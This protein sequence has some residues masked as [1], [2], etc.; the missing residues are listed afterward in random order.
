KAVEVIDESLARVAA[1]LD[2][3][4]GEM[5][6]TAD[7]GN[8]EQLHDAATGQ[9]HTAHT[10]NLVPFVYYGAR[11]VRMDGVGVPSDIAPSLLVLLGLPQP[12]EMT[13]KALLRI[14]GG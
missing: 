2:E 4:G 12:P 6:I 3:S 8:I 11:P 13:G 10:T 9:A 14:A 1:A 5:L 7:H